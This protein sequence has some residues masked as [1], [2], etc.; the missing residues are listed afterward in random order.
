MEVKKIHRCPMCKKTFDTRRECKIHKQ[1]Q[2]P[3]LGSIK[4]NTKKRKKSLTR[5]KQSIWSFC[6]T[7]NRSK[8][9][10]KRMFV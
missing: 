8:H 3:G 1:L 5:P 2:H 6:R 7:A 9:R 10:P 4:T